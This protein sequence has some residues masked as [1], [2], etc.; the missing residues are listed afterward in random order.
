MK[1]ILLLVVAV[2]VLA[3]VAGCSQNSKKNMPA[4]GAADGAAP[5][6]TA[7]DKNVDAVLPELAA[8]YKGVTV[9]VV[10]V[11][12][13]KNEEVFIPFSTPTKLGAT[14]LT[15]TVL[16]FFPDFVITDA[17]YSSKTLEPNNVGAKVSV[18]GA[19]PE[20]TGW[21]FVNYPEIHPYEG[22]N[23]SLTL[24]NAVKK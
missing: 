16:Q 2:S 8:A 4:G 10:D 1:K 24:I 12:T 11:K 13:K 18:T 23:Y 6:V 20:F 17:G 9:R 21:L 22:D 15:V 19:T 7:A 3:I 5:A 14:P